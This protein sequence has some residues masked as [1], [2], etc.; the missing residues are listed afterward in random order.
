[1]DVNLEPSFFSRNTGFDDEEDEKN[2]KDSECPKPTVIFT[3]CPSVKANLKNGLF[4]T[5]LLVIGCNDM[6]SLALRRAVECGE[7]KM[8]LLG[9]LVM[10]ETPIRTMS[11][12][13]PTIAQQTCMF[14]YL[15]SS[16]L[17]IAMVGG[18][19]PASSAFNVTETI[20]KH[21]D[22][23]NVVLLDTTMTAA[24]E[25]DEEKLSSL[26]CIE[27]SEASSSKGL[28][29]IDS[30]YL[31][32]P[33]MIRGLGAALMIHCEIKSIPARLYTAFEDMHRTLDTCLVFDRLLSSSSIALI[34]KNVLSM[35][36]SNKRLEIKDVAEKAGLDWESPL[37]AQQ[38]VYAEGGTNVP[39]PD[40]IYI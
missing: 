10:E 16:K 5:E 32:P 11:A 6:C 37:Q 39:P 24:A 34:P 22:C 27:T 26:A 33:S 15:P 21:F 29:I 38:L 4:N 13:N 1:M 30:K 28:E 31:S 2:A 36:L 25:A 40:G 19:L 7:N 8:D 23:K 9:S 35:E 3:W 17:T 12:A 18:G 20:F 14:Y